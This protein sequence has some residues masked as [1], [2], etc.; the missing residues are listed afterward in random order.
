MLTQRKIERLT[1]AGRYRDGLM[2]GLYLVVG[3]N[4][5][6][7]WVMRYELRGRERMMG[8][9]S[10]TTFS[11]REAR[12]RARSAR[13][14]LVDGIDPLETKR[15]AKVAAE[16]AAAKNLTFAEAAKR[17]VIQHEAKWTR[18]H[19]DAVIGSLRTY[20]NPIIGNMNVSEIDTAAVLRV[21]EP[22]WATTTET[23]DRVRNRIEAVL[24]W[25]AVRGHR[26]GDNPARWKGH[27][28]QVLP[29]KSELAPVKHHP[30]MPYA[31][32]PTFMA[33]LRAARGIGCRALEFAILT[34]A[35][36]GEVVG[37]RS[38]EVDFDAATWVIPAER[39]KAGRE[40]RV[41]LSVPAIELLR[42]LPREPANDY[43]FIGRKP[44]IAMSDMGLNRALRTLRSGGV[45]VHG[46]RS[47]FRDWCAE[48][49]AYPSD[50]IEIALAHFVGNKVEQ[51]YRRGDMLAKRA[52][53]MKDWAEFCAAPAPAA[54]EVVPIRSGAR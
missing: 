28:D 9:G 20:A 11:L 15:A 3:E 8:L 27:L 41:P 42:N 32:L 29:A 23:I 17:Y 31:E 54:G 52:R 7:S 19:R 37:A 10:V 1:K 22:H 50:L 5:A 14:L 12:E 39:M 13:Q 16:L 34:A 25:A 48:Q 43:V 2:P 21:M 49:T 35:R 53:L 4:G 36:T 44:G 26:T 38:S 47:T 30:A 24:D 46:F 6:R 45:V 33:E 40:H 51:A 18:S